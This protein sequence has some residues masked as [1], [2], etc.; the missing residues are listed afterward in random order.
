[1]TPDRSVERVTHCP[2]DGAA[3]DPAAYGAVADG[4]WFGVRGCPRCRRRV[5]DPRPSEQALATWYG[6]D[7]FGAGDA[8]FIRPVEAFVDWFRDRRARE[9]TAL[10]RP[11]GRSAA[12]APRVLDIGCG[13]GRF[14]EALATRGFDCH[15]TELSAETARRAA[16]APGIAL[17][18]GPIAADTY[19]EQA[20]D[21]I[22]VWHVLEHLPDPDAVLRHCGKWLKENGRLML[23]VPNIDSWQAR[24][25]RGAWLHLD[26]PRHLHHFGPVALRI[27]LADAGLAIE[28]VRHLSWEQNLYGFIQSALNACGFPRDDLYQVLKGNRR[29]GTAPR[30][31]AEGLLAAAL[32]LPAVPLTALEALFRSGGTLEIVA[33]RRARQA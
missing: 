7:Y 28:R 14:L 25:F 3:L 15:G 5:L 22:S 6:S 11:R 30:D 12:G 33:A 9:A 13:S 23:A 27:A 31:F 1:M 29:F 26:P 18:V 2:G 19:A 20:F 8:K 4:V 32:F 24:W 10:L 16:A 21:L 17:H